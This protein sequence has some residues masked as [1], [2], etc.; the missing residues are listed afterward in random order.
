MMVAMN[1]RGL[2]RAVSLLAMWFAVPRGA[3]RRGEAGEGRLAA[4]EP[5]GG[6]GE[7]VLPRPSAPVSWALMQV[8]CAHCAAYSELGRISKT[9]DSIALGHDPA[10][11]DRERLDAL[12]DL[13]RDLFMQLCL[14]PAVNDAER[15][16]KAT[17]LLAFCN[18]DEFEREHVEALL[19]S[20]GG[21]TASGSRS[22]SRLD[23]LA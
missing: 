9:I 21:A 8:M 14:H 10:P 6:A 2:L 12:G 7:T 1:R 4:A 16:E 18:G 15:Q 5:N 13:E 22:V 11:A 23:R 17:Y 20:M 3:L 19:V